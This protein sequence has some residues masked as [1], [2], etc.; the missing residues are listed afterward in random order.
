[1]TNNVWG[2][3]DNPGRDGKSDF[4]IE[5]RDNKVW[6][7]GGDR[8]TFNPFDPFNYLQVDNDVWRLTFVPEPSTVLLSAMACCLLLARHPRQRFAPPTS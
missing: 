3:E 7:F 8:E 1:M 5:V 4:M 2:C 6:T